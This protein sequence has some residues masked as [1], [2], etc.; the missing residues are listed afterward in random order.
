MK[1]NELEQ[2]VNLLK[3]EYGLSDN[4]HWEVTAAAKEDGCWLLTVTKTIEDKGAE[5]ESN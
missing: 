4:D 2:L 5:N 1:K 3:N